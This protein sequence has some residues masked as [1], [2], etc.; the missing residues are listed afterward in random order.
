VNATVFK[1]RAILVPA[2]LLIA[3]GNAGAALRR[4]GAEPTGCLGE[5]DGHPFALIVV[6]LL[7]GALLLVM[8]VVAFA[9]LSRSSPPNKR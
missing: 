1:R 9:A 4:S 6:H 5:L 3:A 2:A 8:L 7:S